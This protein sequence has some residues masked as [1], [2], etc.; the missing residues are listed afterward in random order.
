MYKRQPTINVQE[1][2][3]EGT[4]YT[5][6]YKDQAGHTVNPTSPGNYGV[7]VEIANPNY[8]FPDGSSF[9][10]V[11]TFTVISGIPTLY[12]VSFDGN[13]ATDGI[14]DD[15]KLGGGGILTLPAC[16]YSKED[17]QFI[18]WMYSGRIYQPGDS[19][20]MPYGHV[21]FKARCV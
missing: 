19:F 2:L 1:N 8:C 16:D 15:L 3:T 21:C 17:H 4:D 13:S 20:T 5:V 18:G 12:T 10:Q 6:I 9:T 14:M 11:G 7:W